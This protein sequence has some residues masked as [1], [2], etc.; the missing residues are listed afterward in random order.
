MITIW[1]KREDYWMNISSPDFVRDL[2]TGGYLETQWRVSY[3]LRGLKKN[4]M[5]LLRHRLSELLR[6]GNTAD[7]GL[8]LRGCKDISGGGSPAGTVQK[9]RESEAGEAA[10]AGK[11]SLLHEAVFLLCWEEVPSHDRQGCCERT[12]VELACGQ[13]AGEGMHAGATSAQSG[14]GSANN[15]DRRDI[16]TEG[17][18]ISYRSQRSGARA[19]DLVWR[20]RPVRGEHGYVL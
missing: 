20:E 19:S 3:D 11:Q 1:E 17:T 6:Q 16:F 8:I 14:G 10:M 13:G 9:V 4:G 5:W 7:T 2:T 15:R 18:H 12:E